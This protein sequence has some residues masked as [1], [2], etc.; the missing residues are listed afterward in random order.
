MMLCYSHGVG[1]CVG[2]GGV[3]NSDA[4]LLKKSKVAAFKSVCVL[5]RV[6][7]PSQLFPDNSDLLTFALLFYYYGPTVRFVTL[8]LHFFPVVPVMCPSFG[9]DCWHCS[10]ADLS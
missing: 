5:V 6:S 7:K 8:L 10:C 1:Y 4:R 3:A 9:S 2:D